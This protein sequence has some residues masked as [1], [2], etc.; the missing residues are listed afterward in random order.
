MALAFLVVVYLNRAMA[1]KFE[2]VGFEGAGRDIRRL[3]P[4]VTRSA[5]RVVRQ[6]ADQLKQDISTAA[7][8]DTGELAASIKAKISADGL[9]AVVFSDNETA[10][11]TEF[12]GKRQAPQPFFLSTASQK[13]PAI[14]RAIE[15]AIEQA[16][17]Q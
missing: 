4:K 13:S 1:V 7:P 14:R 8:V 15:L 16:L 6:S 2:L 11:L 9:T 3:G 10:R 12:G 17:K 5:R